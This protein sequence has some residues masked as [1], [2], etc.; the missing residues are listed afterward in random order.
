ML[1]RE[2]GMNRSA[3]LSFALALQKTLTRHRRE[4][5]IQRREKSEA[6]GHVHRP[7]SK[8]KLSLP[9]VKTAEKEK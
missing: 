2:T 9:I 6:N 8:V 3:R 5:L 7:K 4:E 1:M